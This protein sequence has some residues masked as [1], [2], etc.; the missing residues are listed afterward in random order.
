MVVSY[1]FGSTYGNPLMAFDVT[2]GERIWRQDPDLTPEVVGRRGEQILTIEGVLPGPTSGD[3]Y[4]RA[5]AEFW[6]GVIDPAAPD[7]TK[8]LGRIRLTTTG[9]HA[10][11]SWDEKNLYVHDGSTLT[12]YDLPQTGD[13]P[14]P[15]Y[16]EPGSGRVWAEDD[17]T[18]VDVVDSCLAIT[19]TTIEALGFRTD[20]PRPSGCR[21]R[22]T[23][24]PDDHDKT[25]YVEIFPISEVDP[26]AATRQ[27][28]AWKKQK[29]A[30]FVAAM[31]PVDGLGD[32]AWQATQATGDTFTSRLIARRRN[33][34][35]IVH[36]QSSGLRDDAPRPT[37]MQARVRRVFTD[38]D[39]DLTRILDAR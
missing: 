25:M 29:I 18:N 5:G 2:T 10:L 38:L 13:E 24:R 7:V 23:A 11:F 3:G 34:V 27:V 4:S 15:A 1:G 39:A 36:Y 21:W 35:V 9:S 20:L 30:N 37:A 8:A 14:M 16:P 19:D 26:G 6:I 12:A 17:L 33:V 31:K 32:E 22:E 28:Q